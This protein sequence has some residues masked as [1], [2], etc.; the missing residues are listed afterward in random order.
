MRQQLIFLLVL[1]TA[2]FCFQSQNDD[3]PTDDGKNC[4]VRLSSGYHRHF[5]FIGTNLGLSFVAGPY[6][7]YQN[8]YLSFYEPNDI[9]IWDND[10]KAL[11][12]NMINKSVRPR[13]LLLELTEY[14]LAWLSVIMMRDNGSLYRRFTVSDEINL[15]RSLGA[16]YQ[17]PWSTSVFL[18]DISTYWE[19]DDEF[20]LQVA[21]RGI[22]GFVLTAGHNQIFQSRLVKSD[23]WRLEWKMKGEGNPGRRKRFWDFKAGYRD[24]GIPE[25]PNTLTLFSKLHNTDK[26]QKGWQLTANYSWTIELQLSS[27]NLSDLTRVYIDYTKYKSIGKLLLGIRL[28]W[29]QEHFPEY[30]IQ[31]DTF[32]EAWKHTNQIILQPQLIF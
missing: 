21:A 4:L 12:R 16:G 14:P 6:R 32:L 30:D 8:I 26:N 31:T 7:T 11:F 28:G 2:S 1:L 29:L 9:D 5:E 27:K 18:G 19:L 17:E 20:N 15:I 25:I 23:W 10:I 24:Y 22:S 3:E 13:F